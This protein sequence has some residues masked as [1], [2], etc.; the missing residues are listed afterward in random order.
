MT[1]LKPEV[2]QR[3]VGDVEECERLGRA[4]GWDT[5]YVQLSSG[6]YNGIYRALVLPEMLLSFED[7]GEA[8]LA[9]TGSQPSLS[10]PIL[11]PL[12]IGSSFRLKGRSVN[13]DEAV[14]TW[15]DH[16]V[17]FAIQGGLQF[18][19][20][21]LFNN[22]HHALLQALPRLQDGGREE[23]RIGLSIT[24][25]VVARLKQGLSVVLGNDRQPGCG[26][27]TALSAGFLSASVASLLVEGLA[28]RQGGRRTGRHGSVRPSY[29]NRVRDIMEANRCDPLSL[30]TLSEEAGTCARTLSYA[31]TKHFGISPVKYHTLKRLEGARRDL[32]RG[33]PEETTVTDIA[34]AWGFWHF[35]RFAQAYRLQFGERPSET[36]ARKPSRIIAGPL[37]LTQLLAGRASFASSDV[38]VSQDSD[39]SFADA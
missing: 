28:L 6:R 37:P 2:I 4:E 27:L 19:T 32:K 22:T 38:V 16:E 35:G 17:D 10:K 15:Q 23:T 30:V 8:S 1:K 9:V 12:W 3:T 21:Q 29:L 25:A 13:T 18:Y 39:V 11:L 5:E 20:I 34:T 7:Y 14:I 26:R 33:C 24:E 31:F 36:L